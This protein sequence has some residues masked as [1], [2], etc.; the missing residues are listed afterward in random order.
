[1]PD[2][3]EIKGNI[4]PVA[5]ITWIEY[6]TAEQLLAANGG[7]EVI[8]PVEPEGRTYVTLRGTPVQQWI[9]GDVRDE[10]RAL[11]SPRGGVRR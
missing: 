2:F 9:A 4:L 10:F 1:M 8:P 5:A 11:L 7:V 3:I 6:Y